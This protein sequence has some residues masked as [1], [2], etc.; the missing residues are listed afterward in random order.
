MGVPAGYAAIGVC[1]FFFIFVLLILFFLGE[2]KYRSLRAI[3][4]S[5][6]TAGIFE[7]CLANIV[8]IISQIK[9]F[10]I[11]PVYLY[12]QFMDYVY[13]CIGAVVASG[14]FLIVIGIAIAALTWINK[15]KGK[16]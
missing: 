11:Y 9:K 7:I 13:S 6:F 3:S 16:R 10:D 12:N 4:I 5:F 14:F 1:S 15:V 8:L 2:K